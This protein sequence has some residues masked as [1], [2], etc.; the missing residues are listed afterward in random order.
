MLLIAYK[1]LGNTEEFWEFIMRNRLK[2]TEAQFKIAIKGLRVVKDDPTRAAKMVLVQ[3]KSTKES[4]EKYGLGTT[5]VSNKV[6]RILENLT[7]QLDE[8]NKSFVTCI[9]DNDLVS[10]VKALEKKSM[11]SLNTKSRKK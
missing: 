1:L 10:T 9:V 7:T 3:G 5:N 6:I 2:L 4:A 8:N 11:E